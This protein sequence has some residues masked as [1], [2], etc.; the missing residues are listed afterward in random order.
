VLSESLK[1]NTPE[2]PEKS[3]QAF[4]RNLMNFEGYLA[5]ILSLLTN[6]SDLLKPIGE[7][8]GSLFFPYGFLITS[9]R[10]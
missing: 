7:K 3:R 9:L 10:S 8:A 1:S 2:N 5:K 6:G 4:T